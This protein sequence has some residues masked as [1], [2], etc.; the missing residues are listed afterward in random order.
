MLVGSVALSGKVPTIL[1]QGVTFPISNLVS[2]NQGNKTA[3]KA[4]NVGY[5]SHDFTVE[6]LQLNVTTALGYVPAGVT[7]IAFVVRSAD[8]D[9]GTPAIIQSL[10]LGS[11]TM[12]TGIDT[13]KAGT[14][15]L[16]VC[17]P[18]AL[19]EATLIHLKVTTAAAT[20]VAGTVSVSALYYSS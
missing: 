4:L 19:T 15:K 16:Y 18:T 17:T 13:G 7:V 11:T 3:D 10:I 8:L 14:V 12:V 9:S 5:V 20:A 6:E 2:P 1:A